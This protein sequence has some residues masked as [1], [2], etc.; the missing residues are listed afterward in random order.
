MTRKYEIEIIFSECCKSRKLSK[1]FKT[2]KSAREWC[3]RQGLEPI[4]GGKRPSMFWSKRN[5]WN[6]RNVQATIREV[7]ASTWLDSSTEGRLRD[8]A[9][10]ANA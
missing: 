1:T 8:A 5:R 6:E 2:Q 9:A 4:F 10:R 7:D 3:A